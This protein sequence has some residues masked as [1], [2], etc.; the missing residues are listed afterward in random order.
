MLTKLISKNF[1]NFKFLNFLNKYSLRR[2]PL[3]IFT[4]KSFCTKVDN[5]NLQTADEEC[6]ASQ[7]EEKIDIQI[8][9]KNN[10]L[11]TFIFR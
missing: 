10:L 7:V 3:P 6:A 2:F 5:T 8:N 11:I 4:Q 9:C 1:T